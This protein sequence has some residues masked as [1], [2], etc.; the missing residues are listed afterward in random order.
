MEITAATATRFIN[1]DRPSYLGGYWMRNKKSVGKLD[2]LKCTAAVIKIDGEPLVL[3]SLDV[4]AIYMDM[5]ESIFKAVEKYGVKFDMFSVAAT[6]T[7][8]SPEIDREVCRAMGLPEEYDFYSVYR[9][10]LVQSAIETI[11]EAFESEFV[12]VEALYKTVKVEGFY[13][14]R[15]GKELP[16]DK[17]VN[18]VKFA[19]EDGTVKAGLVNISCHPT[20][21][22]AENYLVSSDLLGFISRRFMAEWGVYPVMVQGSAGDMSNRNFR[23]G[24][25]AAEL[26][27]TGSGVCAQLMGGGYK[28]LELAAPNV[29]KYHYSAAY[30]RD[31]Q[32]LKTVESEL[33]SEAEKE[34]DYEQHRLLVSKIL[35]VRQCLMHPDVKVDIDYS[36]LEV[37]EMQFIRMPG[38]LFSRFGMQ[39]K[40]ASSKKLP[41]IWCYVNDESGYMPG[42][43]DYGVTYES[44]MT[45]LPKGATEEITENLVRLVGEQ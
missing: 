31:V 33:V 4:T 39:I 19:A 18:I 44:T 37:G 25:D 20:V 8:A 10:Y 2:D 7:H 32:T 24:H 36:V 14:N 13:G 1:P 15:V 35:G 3:C 22:G 30:K 5:T 29:K 6:H 16:G 45:D 38:E 23:M 40:R 42:R 28:P 43:E 21:L 41:M 17:D 26:E 11:T 27:R 9:R 12:P 34:K